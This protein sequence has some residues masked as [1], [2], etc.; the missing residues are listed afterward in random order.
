MAGSRE[1]AI[2]LAMATCLVV[3]WSGMAQSYKG[4][5]DTRLTI[6]VTTQTGDKPVGNASVYVRF[7]E[8][9]GSDKLTELDLKTNEDGRVKVPPIPQGRI[10]VQVVAEGKKTFGQW[11]DVE[12]EQK[13]IHIQ[14]EPPA[15]WY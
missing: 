9:P 11:F 14:L 2:V 4:S 7:P 15:H 5:A 6:V 1:R 13:T 10:M 3:A 12:E 8:K